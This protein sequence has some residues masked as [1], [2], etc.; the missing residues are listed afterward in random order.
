MNGSVARG[1]TAD[2]GA[3]RAVPAPVNARL[4]ALVEEVAADPARRAWFKGNPDRLLAELS[5]SE[6]DGGAAVGRTAP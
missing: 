6:A 5:E 1:G 4:T 3:S 2:G